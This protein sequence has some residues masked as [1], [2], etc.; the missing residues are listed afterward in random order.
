MTTFRK[1][2]DLCST[3]GRLERVPLVSNSP[4]QGILEQ[5]LFSER[6]EAR[7]ELV[8][9]VLKAQRVEG[10]TR[11]RNELEWIASRRLR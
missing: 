6:V 11:D 5:F 3:S 1:A 7:R 9:T 8:R 2:T 10:S 4:A